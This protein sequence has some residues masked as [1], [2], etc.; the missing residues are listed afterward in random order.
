MSP[1]E[2]DSAEEGTGACQTHL[3]ASA[4]CSSGPGCVWC[5]HDQ[6]QDDSH[7]ASSLLSQTPDQEWCLPAL[8]DMETSPL[9][10]SV[11]IILFADVY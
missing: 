11:L 6:D 8:G 7:S 1:G 2:M 3:W 5:H 10:W 4:P 9:K